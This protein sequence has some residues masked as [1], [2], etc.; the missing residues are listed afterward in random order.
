MTFV[1]RSAVLFA[2]VGLTLVALLGQNAAVAS[3]GEGVFFAEGTITPGLT[4]TCTTQTQLTADSVVE[5]V[6]NGN[7]ETGS[8]HFAGASNGCES[9]AAGSGSGTMT[10]VPTG[11]VSY[12]RRGNI[13]TFTG[14]AT[15][16]CI[17][18]WTSFNP[19]TND[20]WFCVG[21]GV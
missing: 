2:T 21:A 15:M 18:A 1:N 9:L 20:W 4:T 6:L 14:A 12:D 16:V 10:G 5:V 8:F 13:V 19:V 7:I 3:V 17:W 11:P